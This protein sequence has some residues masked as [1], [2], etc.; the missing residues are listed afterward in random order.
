MKV[1]RKTICGMAQAYFTI[2]MGKQ[3]NMRENGKM[4]NQKV[5]FATGLRVNWLGEGKYFFENGKPKYEGT[6]R[7]DHAE[8]DGIMYNQAG[9][10]IYVGNFAGN[11]FNGVGRMYRENG[12]P[13]Y[14]GEFKDNVFCGIGKLFYEDGHLS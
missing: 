2:K 9:N 11:K 1:L 13:W 7:D 4:I 8:G 14:E 12:K 5:N 6:L 3:P 10:V